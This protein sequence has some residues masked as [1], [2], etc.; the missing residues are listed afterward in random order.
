[1]I[2]S[3]LGTVI[4]L[5]FE[6]TSPANLD[7]DQF[8]DLTLSS[9][10]RRVVWYKICYG[11]WNFPPCFAISWRCKFECTSTGS[12]LSFLPVLDLEAF[13]SALYKLTL[14]RSCICMLWTIFCGEG[15]NISFV[16]LS[17]GVVCRFINLKLIFMF[18]KSVLCYIK[19]TDLW[20]LR[21]NVNKKLSPFTF[22]CN[23]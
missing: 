14:P 6:P 9:P 23:I 7:D 10:R 8:I 2:S 16:S 19:I 20:R 15:T 1:M 11:P 17:F 18:D 21:T 12:C 3:V 13:P 4:S 22:F 5:G